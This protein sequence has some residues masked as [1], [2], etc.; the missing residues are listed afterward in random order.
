METSMPIPLDSLS[1][2]TL[3]GP[4]PLA[5]HVGL[6]LNDPL[7]GLFD[8]SRQQPQMMHQQTQHAQHGGGRDAK[9]Q[10]N[11]Q[12]QQQQHFD[13]KVVKYSFAPFMFVCLLF[14]FLFFC[15]V[16]VCLSV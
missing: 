15:L 16:C 6:G 10:Q 8:M 12:Q 9:H 7:R 3:N 2:H 14:C 11:Y 1:L 4:D 5:S 13:E